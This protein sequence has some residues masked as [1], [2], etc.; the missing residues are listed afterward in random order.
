M[1]ARNTGVTTFSY[2]FTISAGEYPISVLINDV[3][4]EP[5]LLIDLPD[6]RTI[7]NLIIGEV[8]VSP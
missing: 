5:P 7:F 6:G 8:S 4:Q 2:P 3:E 1:I